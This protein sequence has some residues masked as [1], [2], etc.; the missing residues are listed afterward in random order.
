MEGTSL[1]EFQLRDHDGVRICHMR[2]AAAGLI[3]FDT[4]QKHAGKQVDVQQATRRLHDSLPLRS[5]Q[6]ARAKSA[7]DDH[8]SGSFGPGLIALTT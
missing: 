3:R 8:D 2:L 5:S 4:T 6:G 1:Q 7:L